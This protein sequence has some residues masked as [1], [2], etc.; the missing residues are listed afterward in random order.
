MSRF[1]VVEC[2]SETAVL[3][4]P[5]CYRVFGY[6]YFDPTMYDSA[7]VAAALDG[8]RM[9]AFVAIDRGGDA[10]A[11]VALRFRFPTLHLAEVGPLLI[12]PAVP[13]PLS[14]HLL[15]ALI[16]AVSTR[17]RTLA[18]EGG[19]RG[20]V[21]LES[22]WHQLTQRLVH[23]LGFVTTGLFLA[24]QPSWGER[25]RLAPHERAAA[26][27]WAGRSR[28]AAHRRTE[29]VSVRA[30]PTRCRPYGVAPPH[31]FRAT[32]RMVYDEL[33][34]PVT[35][36]P[37]SPAHG[38]SAVST[39]VDAGCSRA[40]VELSHH[41]ADARDVVLDHLAHYRGGMVDVIHFLLPLSATGI[42]GPV[43]AL[44]QAG[45]RY[46]A[47]LPFYRGH[48]VLAL[49]YLNH[50]EAWHSGPPLFS[51]RA[52]RLW[53]EVIGPDPETGGGRLGA[54]VAPP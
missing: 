23:Q 29:T 43:E 22:T 26:G 7:A 38:E 33:G 50:V 44:L 36:V 49:Q 4:P 30:F 37:S 28:R 53:A 2:K 15:R 45:C 54:T 35:F 17:V 6:T 24:W 11:M 8:G 25:V 51:P 40:V 32:L 41:G 1:A 10:R 39:A 34:L 9:V 20:L 46:G 3:V 21:S 31:R 12:D 52:R 18:G 14:G 48:D 16:E 5:L 27:T 13:A 42:D 19:L 47:L